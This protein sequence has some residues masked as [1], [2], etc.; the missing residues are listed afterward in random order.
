MAPHQQYQ[1]SGRLRVRM[2]DGTKV[3]AGNAET[4][5]VPQDAWVSRRPL[6]APENLA[7]QHP[8]GADAPTG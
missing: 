5:A 6:L 4:T 8:F 1:Q 7:L 3:L 2:E